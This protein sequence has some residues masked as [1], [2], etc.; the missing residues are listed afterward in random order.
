MALEQGI[1]VAPTHLF[2][3]RFYIDVFIQE[4][5]R[6]LIPALLRQFYDL[7]WVTGTG[8]GIS[9]KDGSVQ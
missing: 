5:P 6:N 3:S 8:G 1:L 7:G 4:H 9:I 2:L